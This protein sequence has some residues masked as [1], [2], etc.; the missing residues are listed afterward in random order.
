MTVLAALRTAVALI[1]V[2]ASTLLLGP[3]TILIGWLFN[4]PNLPFQGNL[5]TD[6]GSPSFRRGGSLVSGPAVGC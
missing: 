5:D 1:V 3:P 2:S 6:G 4:W